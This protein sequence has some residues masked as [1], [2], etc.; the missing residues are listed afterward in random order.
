MEQQNQTDL[1]Q[2]IQEEVNYAD[3]VSP[4]VRFVN[5]IIDQLVLMV[6]FFIT[7]FVFATI[8]YSQGDDPKNYLFFQENLSGKMFQYLISYIVL[9]LYYTLFETAT[10]GRSLGKFVTGT[11]AINQDGTPFTFK[12]AL[13]RSL[14]RIIPFEPFSAFGYMPWH[15][16][17]TKTAVVKKTW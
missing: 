12:N 2:D 8:V 9:V 10:K 17:F 4:G 1:L 15:D 5:F 3:P 6:F 11:I 7:S 14:C 16:K 13:M